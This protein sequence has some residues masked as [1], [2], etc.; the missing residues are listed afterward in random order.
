M[1]HELLEEALTKIRAAGFEPT[2][3]CNRHF[4]I[5]WTNQHGRRQVLVIAM[6]PSDHRARLRSRSILRRLLAP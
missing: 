5:S 3:V 2:V 4:K 6:S 1:R